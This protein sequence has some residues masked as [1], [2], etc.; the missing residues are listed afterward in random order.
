MS[1]SLARIASGTTS[2]HFSRPDGTAELTPASPASERSVR[3]G[4]WI[5]SPSA[6]Q[7]NGR[8]VLL[9]DAYDVVDADDSAVALRGRHPEETDPLIVFVQS[10]R[11]RIGRA[12]IA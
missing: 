10:P 9:S 5:T 2:P 4:Q 12:S 11:V 8:W 7:Y 6:R 3:V 1:A